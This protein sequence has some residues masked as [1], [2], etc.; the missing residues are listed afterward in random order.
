VARTRKRSRKRIER[1]PS[2]V[3][4]EDKRSDGLPKKELSKKDKQGRISTEYSE[5]LTKVSDIDLTSVKTNLD[6][7]RKLRE[8]LIS[9]LTTTRGAFQARPTQGNAYAIS[10]LV[11]KIEDTSVLIE[12]SIDYSALTDAILD[13]ELKPFLDRCLLDLGSHITDVID[14]YGTTIKKKKALKKYFNEAYRNFGVSLELKIP[15]FSDSL[16]QFILSQVR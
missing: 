8:V 12:E 13:Q 10:N 4:R 3:D 9:T 14:R 15:A 6:L 2:F 7:I 11:S 16:K 5:A 1:L